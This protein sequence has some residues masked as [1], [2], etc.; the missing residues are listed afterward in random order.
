MINWHRVPRCSGFFRF[1]LATC[2]VKNRLDNRSGRCAESIKRDKSVSVILNNSL[3]GVAAYRW[4]RMT[5]LVYLE[6]E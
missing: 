4:A 5:A 2:T 1:L 3:A 6:Y